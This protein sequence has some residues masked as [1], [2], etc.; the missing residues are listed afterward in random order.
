[1]KITGL[2][3]DIEKLDDETLKLSAP[4]RPLMVFKKYKPG[5]K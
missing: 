1:L 5:E 2:E 3:G 4:N